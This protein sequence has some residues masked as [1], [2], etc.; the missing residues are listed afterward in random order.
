[1]DN[2]KSACCHEKSFGPSKLSRYKMNREIMIAEI[3]VQRLDRTG[4]PVFVDDEVLDRAGI[5]MET[6]E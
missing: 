1:M 4:D 2:N 3:P 5:D 6:D